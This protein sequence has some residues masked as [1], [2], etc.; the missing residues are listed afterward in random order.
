MGTYGCRLA[1]C[2]CTL[3]LL[4]RE[5]WI[6]GAMGWINLHAS[7]TFESHD[8]YLH[9]TSAMHAK[10][11]HGSKIQSGC[12]ELLLWMAP[13]IWKETK[14]EPGTAGT[15]NM[16]GCCLICFHFLWAILS[17]ITVL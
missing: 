7:I 10:Q 16:L 3:T 13:R 8:V 12:R 5:K 15:G 2:T 17:T 1:Y 6:R 14:Q 9:Q 11:G 4:E